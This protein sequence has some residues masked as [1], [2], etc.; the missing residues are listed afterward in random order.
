MKLL[1]ST[2]NKIT[3][4]E[5]GENIPHLEITEVVLVNCKIIYYLLIVT[6]HYQHDSRVLYTT[7]PNKLFGQLL[8]ISPKNFVFKNL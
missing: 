1:G 3:K 4:G 2:K 6:N 7:V 5:I 8:H